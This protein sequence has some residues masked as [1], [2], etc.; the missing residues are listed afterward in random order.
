MVA[1]S[2]DEASL[3]MT[4][5]EPVF[6]PMPFELEPDPPPQAASVAAIP[7]RSNVPIVLRNIIRFMMTSLLA[8]HAAGMRLRAY[9]E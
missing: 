8:F 7:T 2:S 5:T 3:T 1:Q 6:A 4:G 9:S